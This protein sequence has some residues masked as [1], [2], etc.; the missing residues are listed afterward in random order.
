MIDAIVLAVA[1]PDDPSITS[2]TPVTAVKG[3]TQLILTRKRKD[4]YLG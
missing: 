1:D 2:L 4:G 3:L